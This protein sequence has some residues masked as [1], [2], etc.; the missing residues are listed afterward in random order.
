MCYNIHMK[1]NAK[2]TFT[3]G[4]YMPVKEKSNRARYSGILRY[5]AE[6]PDHDVN[7]VEIANPYRSEKDV[8]Y[9]LAD[10]DGFIWIPEHLSRAQLKRI[11]IVN[12]GLLDRDGY[13]NIT[14]INI[15]DA[16][17]GQSA[18]DLLMRR[19]YASFAFVG[20]ENPMLKNVLR[21]KWGNDNIHSARR[22]RAFEERLAESGHSCRS[23]IF[24][25]AEPDASIC[26][27]SR[28]L[29]SLPKPCGVLAY[30]DELANNVYNACR[31]ARL[32]IPDQI[33]VVG[34]DNDVEI[35]EMLR[36][37][38]TSILPDFEQCGYLAMEALLE[39]IEHPE[40]RVPSRMVGIRKIFERESTQD[41]DGSVRLVTRARAYIADNFGR[42]L[43]VPE[44][45]A[46][47]KASRRL[48]EMKFRQVTGGTV[49]DEIER[50]RMDEAK[51]L[52]ANT[53]RPISEI[54]A[55]CG[56]SSDISFRFAFR[57]VFGAP[58]TSFR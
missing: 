34:V 42:H 2:R 20:I 44:I 46:S 16:P 24:N 33:A 14:G 5:M 43:T 36:P 56:F 39:K 26:G 48:L 17:I 1:N 35:C 58:P 54:S 18:A 28:F 21:F 52:L 8:K 7:L 25:M 22:G 29:E 13:D 32:S 45:A 50:V 51:R 30:N 9:R 11:P 27:L 47:V 6:H 38:L 19:G 23:H 12:F 40:R 55:V 15:D 37:T 10:F 31:L 49:H 3:I 57:R 4:T 53:K 41:V